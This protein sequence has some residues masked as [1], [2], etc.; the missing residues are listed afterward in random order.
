M[1]IINDEYHITN[2]DKKEATR[3][4]FDELSKYCSNHSISLS[5]E[6]YKRANK[7]YRGIELLLIKKMRRCKDIDKVCSICEKIIEMGIKYERSTEHLGLV[8]KILKKEIE[9]NAMD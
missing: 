5:P 9:K 2:E 6:Q 1:Q 4:Y 7:I 8:K 3:I